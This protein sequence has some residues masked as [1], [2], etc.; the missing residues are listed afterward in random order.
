[1]PKMRNDAGNLYIHLG[2]LA[3]YLTV[4][5]PEAGMDFIKTF[6]KAALLDVKGTN[7]NLVLNGFSLDD[8]VA[9]SVLSVFGE[10]TPT[11]FSIKSLISNRTVLLS[12]YGVSEGG[13]FREQLMKS[14]LRSAAVN[15]TLSRLANAHKLDLDALYSSIDDEVAIA[16]VEK[17]SKE[18]SRI[19]IVEAKDTA[20][21]KKCFE[22]LADAYSTDT[23]FFEK[24]AGYEIR[25]IP[26]FQFPSKIFTPF[27]SGFD[28]SFYTL[29]N[30]TIIIGD[31]LEELKA[32]LADIDKEE[33]WGKSVSQNRFLETTLLESNISLYVNTPRIWNI[34]SA[35][36][37]ERWTRFIRQHRTEL[38]SAGMGAIQ[39]SHL[40]QSFYTNVTWSFREAS[41]A[42]ETP[43]TSEVRITNFNRALTGR[44]HPVRSHVDK[45]DE[46]IIQDSAHDV[47]LVSAAGKVLWSKPM[48][49]P[50]AGKVFQVDYFKNGKL[51]YYFATQGALHIIDRLGN[52]VTPFPVRLRIRDLQYSSLVDYD[53]SKS[54]RFLLADKSGKLWMFDKEGKNLEGWK[55]KNIEDELFAAPS[56]VR[57]KGKD[58]LIA[59]RKDGRV[60]VFNRRGDV[61]KGF[62]LA[63]DA[64]PEGDYFVEMGDSPAKTLVVLV[65]RDGFRIKLNLEGKVITKET[66]LKTTFEARFRLATE[67][68]G[69]SYVMV[70]Q[71]P[72][73]L[74]LFDSN[75]SEIITNEFVALSPS[76][77]A[78][79]D[80]GAGRV[81]YVIEDTGQELCYVYDAQYNL[82]TSPPWEGI[83][84]AIRPKGTSRVSVYLTDGN[85]VHLRS[86]D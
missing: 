71:E 10:Q 61:L 40:N 62:P 74:S 35:K 67:Q 77:V 16:Y 19:M 4:F 64:R 2:H 29:T 36:V 58:Y 41:V 13:R 28:Q 43:A 33:T 32:F 11:P 76:R 70:R 3:E 83:G 27:V 81:Y 86:L 24:Y 72:K 25:E 37:G 50:I 51:Q 30:N 9:G 38:M 46:L 5:V 26:I 42:S 60:Y 12:S 54:Y 59:I 8:P 66:L 68:N 57:I 55:P 49:G 39:F 80:L 79:Y 1:M 85:S 45:S 48:D 17:G 82:L 56:H 73:G 34:L 52:Y 69:K 7:E 23:V 75:N 18:L 47:H 84:A 22:A 65:T 15:D 53:R 6:G 31:G 44:I 63:L 21:W 20:P 78:Q 14:K